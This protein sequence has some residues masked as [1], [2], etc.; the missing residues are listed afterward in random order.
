M[1]NSKESQKEVRE[2]EGDRSA[3]NRIVSNV[4]LSHKMCVCVCVCVCV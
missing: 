4:S 3:V 1:S 2:L